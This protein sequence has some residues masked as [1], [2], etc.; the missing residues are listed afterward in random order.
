MNSDTRAATANRFHELVKLPQKDDPVERAVFALK[1]LGLE[2]R[3][4]Y[5]QTRAS[6]VKR[7]LMDNFARESQHREGACERTSIRS[8]SRTPPPRT[9]PAQP[10]PEP[11]AVL[12]VILDSRNGFNFITTYFSRDQV[13]KFWI[14]V[15][16][17]DRPILEELFLAY[18]HG[19]D[20]A[21][22][23]DVEIHICSRP[24]AMKCISHLECVPF[25]VHLYMSDTFHHKYL[26]QQCKNG[27]VL[28]LETSANLTQAHLQRDQSDQG[29]ARNHDSYTP[30]TCSRNDWMDRYWGTVRPTHCKV[31]MPTI[32]GINQLATVKADMWNQ[33]MAIVASARTE[34]LDNMRAMQLQARVD[35]IFSHPL[36]KAVG[37]EV[38]CIQCGHT[39]ETGGLWS[40]C[41]SRSLTEDQWKAFCRNR[42]KAM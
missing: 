12:P 29:P 23:P 24:E 32:Q 5:H 13:G 8:R 25:P 4:N 3:Y 30:F 15:P 40:P 7:C 19:D 33:S 35:A 26:A 6:E 17:M 39:F 11:A 14:Q 9:R 1:M 31:V 37:G 21:W 10:T 34:G 38:Q 20:D 22:N 42:W 27:S 28:V 36:Q 18:F 41:R 2:C 16:F